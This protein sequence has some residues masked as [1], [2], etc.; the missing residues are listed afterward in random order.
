MGRDFAGEVVNVG[1]G[2]KN[3]SNGDQV[4]GVVGPQ[5]TGTHAEYVVTAASNVSYKYRYVLI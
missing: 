3:V 1:H 5:R 4:L 2:V